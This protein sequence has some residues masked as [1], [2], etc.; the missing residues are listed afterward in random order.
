MS[1][2]SNPFEHSELSPEDL[3]VVRAFHATDRFAVFQGDQGDRE[4]A[5]TLHGWMQHPSLKMKC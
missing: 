2:A 3:E 4:V 5:R 1:E